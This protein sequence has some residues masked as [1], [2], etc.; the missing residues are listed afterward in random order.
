M[1][2]DLQMEIFNYQDLWGNWEIINLVEIYFLLLIYV[3][4]DFLYFT[5]YYWS[6]RNVYIKKV[7]VFLW[8][9]IFYIKKQKSMEK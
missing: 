3:P 6:Y 8:V 9:F 1:K 7:V 2:E 5:Q 4:V